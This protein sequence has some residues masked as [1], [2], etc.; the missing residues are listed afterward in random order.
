MGGELK[1]GL[2]TAGGG[3]DRKNETFFGT[4]WQLLENN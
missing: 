1:M 2:L 4:F 3:N